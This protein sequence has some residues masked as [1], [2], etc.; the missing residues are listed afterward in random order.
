METDWLFWMIGAIGFITVISYAGAVVIDNSY[1]DRCDCIYIEHTIIEE[2]DNRDEI[3]ALE[4]QIQD[5]KD[6]IVYKDE[7][8]KRKGGLIMRPTYAE[9]I[10]F[11]EEDKTDERLWMKEFDCTQ[12]SYTVIR[13]AI[14]KGI[15][16]CV[17]ELNLEV[18]HNGYGGH[19]IVVFH[20]IDQGI[21]YFEPQTDKRVLMYPGVSYS[22]YLE[23][24]GDYKM[25]VDEYDSCFERVR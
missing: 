25:W 15:Y 18:P 1:N 19:D 10:E 6:I 2:V 17:A 22:E 20:T 3:T 21:V 4:A 12:F 16:G 5:Y 11:L 23:H 14:G 13:N 8:F 24:L 9:V 7:M